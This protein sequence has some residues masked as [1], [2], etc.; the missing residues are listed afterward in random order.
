M[1]EVG[2]EGLFSGF[3]TSAVLSP[4]AQMLAYVTGSGNEGGN[5]LLR[6]LD[7]FES[8]TIATG[9]ARD[10]SLPA[11]LFARRRVARL[12]HPGRAQK[13]LDRRRRTDHS[14]QGGPQPRG[15]LGK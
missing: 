3:G 12:R 7:R 15:K 14:V 9:G 2:E 10:G 4:D 1:I 13:G 5:I 11:L 6:H 8:T